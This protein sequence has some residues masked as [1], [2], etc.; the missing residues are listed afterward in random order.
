MTRGVNQVEC[1][2]ISVKRLV[3]QR[4]GLRLDRD[5]SLLFEI[6]GVEHLLLHLPVTQT[7]T[8][9][10]QSVSKR[11]LAMVNVGDD[12]EVANPLHGIRPVWADGGGRRPISHSS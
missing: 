7:A 6:H 10:D 8:A 11:R 2:D 4:S 5:P 9:L 3:A 12:R 1:V